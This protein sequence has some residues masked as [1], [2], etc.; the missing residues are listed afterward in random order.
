MQKLLND[1]TDRAFLVVVF[2]ALSFPGL[3]HAQQDEI[4]PAPAEGAA[5]ASQSERIVDGRPVLHS[6]KRALH[7]VAWFESGF[8]PL[9]RLAERAGAGRLESDP[10]KLPPVSG[11]KFGIRGMGS[12]SGIGPEI[13]PFH[14]NL[15]NRGIE[16]EAP[17]VL[18]Y[19][20][21][22]SGRMRVSFPL[23]GA[24]ESS[25]RLG[26]E[27]NGRY[28]SRAQDKFFGVGNDSSISDEARFRSVTRGA[29]AALEARVKGDWT[30][31]AE[32]GYRSIGITRPRK[33]RD[34]REVF[35]GED[36]PGLT[37]EPGATF[38]SA[39]VLLQRDTRDDPN[40]TSAGG[41]QRVEA[42]LHEGLTG[43]DFAYWR[44]SAEIQQFI[45]LG[46]DHRKVISL[47]ANV[48]TNREKGGSSIPFFDL[49]FIGS[50]TTVRG[51]ESRRFTDKSAMSL[52]AGYQYRIW[53]Y[54][55]WGFFAD[56]GQV[57]PEIGDFD[58]DSLHVGYGMRF[59]VRTEG[60][61]G[62]TFDVARSREAPWM[63]YVDF[64][65]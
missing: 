22:Q 58:V 57:A 44:Y 39:T 12:G 32:L 14:N 9:A 18:T 46:E 36:I 8:L 31:R 41:L 48:E 43:G 16:F 56:A 52:S 26:F 23:F 27:I 2:V 7:P 21:Y 25:S 49:P 62:I 61:R 30:A 37:S 54:F 63:V 19:K 34:A 13:K 4:P 40:L 64:N 33:F 28:V 59:V 6:V 17:M 11:V 47:R 53:R 60:H 1:R 15:L 45:P 38:A 50:R 51:Y 42:S 24:G 5:I 35:S 65:F 3:L 29:G 10:D 55:D 20:F